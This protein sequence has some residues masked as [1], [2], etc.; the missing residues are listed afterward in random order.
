[1]GSEFRWKIGLVVFLLLILSGLIFILGLESKSLESYTL[2]DYLF[3]ISNSI[4]ISIIFLFYLKRLEA[5]I[6]SKSFN[7]LSLI[8]FLLSTPFCVFLALGL[9]IFIFDPLL[10]FSDLRFGIDGWTQLGVSIIYFILGISIFIIVSLFYYFFHNNSNALSYFLFVTIILTIILLVYL[11]SLVMTCKFYDDGICLGKKAINR[12]DPKIC[13]KATNW[14]RADDCYH[15]LSLVWKDL[16]L[17][18]QIRNPV[19]K[20]LCIGNIND[21]TNLSK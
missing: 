16:R 2:I 19:T 4:F 5:K 14:V 7:F 9:A 1:M 11:I 21:N 6:N 15:K 12:N 10:Y 20:D 3:I 8:R 13:E 18:N 17:C